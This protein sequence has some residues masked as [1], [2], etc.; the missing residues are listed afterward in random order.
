[1]EE[2]PRA[3]C[4]GASCAT[5]SED[6]GFK[7]D[8]GVGDLQE[9][10][11]LGKADFFYG[12]STQ[13]VKAVAQD[14]IASNARDDLVDLAPRACRDPTSD[15]AALRAGRPIRAARD[16]DGVH[17]AAARARGPKAEDRLRV[18]RHRV[19]R[20]GIRA[21]RRGPRSSAADRRR[22]RYQAVGIDVRPSRELRRAEP[23]I[24]IF[25]GYILAPMPDFVR[26]LREAGP[27]P[28]IMG[29]GW[30]PRTSRRTTRS[31]RSGAP[32]RA[33]MYRYGHETDSP[34]INNMREYLAKNAPEVKNISPF[35]VSSW[36]SGM[37]FAEIAERC[38]RRTSRYVCRT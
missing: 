31:A 22:D 25:Q 5:S 36:L 7:L 1:V 20:D 30:G 33:S 37:I 34:M 13:W 29:H 24:G 38:S 10:H 3:A 6:S 28:Q 8:Q 32:D 14:A 21:A 27:N 19:R 9:D 12:D 11:G 35:Y 17:R 18:R 15:A 4:C 2:Q 16:P 26:Q 23:D